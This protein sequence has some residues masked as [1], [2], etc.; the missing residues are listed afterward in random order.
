MHGGMTSVGHG[1]RSHDCVC[2]VATKG[3]VSI[4]QS[5]QGGEGGGGYEA[6]Y[7]NNFFLMISGTVWA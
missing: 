1:A 7:T 5:T 4:C 6:P 2:G 3:Y